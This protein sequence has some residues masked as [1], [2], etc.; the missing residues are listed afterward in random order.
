MTTPLTALTVATASV[1]LLHVPPLVLLAS[2]VFSPVQTDAVPVLAAGVGFTVIG[3]AAKQLPGVVVYVMVNGPEDTPVT[4]PDPLLTVALAI[5]LLVHVPPPVRS[6]KVVVSPVHT[7]EAPVGAGG[8]A[9]TV[10]GSTAVQPAG[11]V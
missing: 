10:K 8:V 6:D 4:S 9:L 3:H 2:V 7:V 1:T 11:N 5:L